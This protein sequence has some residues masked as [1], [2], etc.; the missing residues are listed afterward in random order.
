[1]QG[2]AYPQ[3]PFFLFQGK[4]GVPGLPGYPGRQ[5]PKVIQPTLGVPVDTL[6]FS[7]VPSAPSSI[8]HPWVAC[9]IAS[10][11]TGSLWLH[12]LYSQPFVLIW[13]SSKETLWQ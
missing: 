8:L 6:G 4:L 1:M 11:V 7:V 9:D 12:V 2:Q 10:G 5:G 3:C 13:P